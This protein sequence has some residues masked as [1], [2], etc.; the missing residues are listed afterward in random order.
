[1]NGT[2]QPDKEY[3]HKSQRDCECLASSN[4][5]QVRENEDRIKLESN[6]GSEE[7]SAEGVP[8]T[9][10]SRQGADQEHAINHIAVLRSQVPTNEAFRQCKRRECGEQPPTLFEEPD[11]RCAETDRKECR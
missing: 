3:H 2:R 1:E 10:E 5:P 6:A 8:A 4:P 11:N 7:Q 9:L